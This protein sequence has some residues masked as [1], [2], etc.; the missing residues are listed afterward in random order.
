MQ[1][2]KYETLTLSQ[3][4]HPVD[5]LL[6]PT[7]KQS[8]LSKGHIEKAERISKTYDFNKK[9]FWMEKHESMTVTLS[10]GIDG[11]RVDN[12]KTKPITILK[13]NQ[14]Q[15]RIWTIEDH[16]KKHKWTRLSP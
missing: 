15:Q 12:L 9:N 6:P 14:I 13:I 10:Q 5:V 8:Y 4:Q 2:F 11:A 7:G 1:L 3:Q 16:N